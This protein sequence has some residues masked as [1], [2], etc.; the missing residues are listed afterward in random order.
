MISFWEGFDK[1]AGKKP[2]GPGG[3]RFGKPRTESERGKRHGTGV[4]PP[5]GTGA[6]SLGIKKR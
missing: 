5:K 3:R 2:L 1:R 6:A 4:L